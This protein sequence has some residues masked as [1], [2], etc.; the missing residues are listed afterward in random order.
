MTI[1]PKQTIHSKWAEDLNRHFSKEDKQRANMHMKR[2]S[3]WLFIREM[4]IKT[5]ISPHSG[6][7]GYYQKIQKH[8]RRCGEKGTLLH[9]WWNVNW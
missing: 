9:C 2:C 7:N 5:T 6:Q 3:T 1:A 4:P 8:A